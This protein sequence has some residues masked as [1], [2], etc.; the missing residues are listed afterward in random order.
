MKKILISTLVSVACFADLTNITTM[1]ADF[2]QQI[3][4]DNNKTVLY[5]G[6]LFAS[7]PQYALWQYTQP[8]QKN[9]YLYND[10]VTIVEPD[11]EQVIIKHIQSHLNFFTLLQNA[12]KI[13]NTHYVTFYKEKKIFIVT[14]TKNTI[15]SLSYKDEFEND[16]T[17]TFKD[18]K[19]NLPI[20]NTIFQAK[21][22]V[23][24]DV[25]TE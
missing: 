9:I 16:V 17:I 3:V 14:D 25:I 21:I 1:E 20:D 13:D 22:P 6:H 5:K 23:D 4:D 2:T 18:A 12:K 19:I 24:F 10:R 8:V 11:L 7:K 15:H